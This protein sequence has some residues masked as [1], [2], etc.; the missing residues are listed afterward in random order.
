MRKRHQVH[1]ERWRFRLG[2][3][4][5]HEAVQDHGEFTLAVLWIHSSAKLAPLITAKVINET[6]RS[7]KFFEIL[8]SAGSAPGIVA[9]ERTSEFRDFS[10]IEY[11][12]ITLGFVIE[13]E[14][15]RWLTD[16]EISDG[17]TNAL[18]NN[19]RK[20]VVGVTEPWDE[21]P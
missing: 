3:G 7:C 18:K 21:H 10:N 15:S 12:S 14:G 11:Q 6:S 9:T 8:G 20:H 19:Y 5:G 2:A 17:V 4:G 16:K 13:K 1:V